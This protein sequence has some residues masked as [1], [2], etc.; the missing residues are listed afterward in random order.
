MSIQNLFTPKKKHRR[1]S[2]WHGSHVLAYI[3]LCMCIYILSHYLYYLVGAQ[4]STCCPFAHHLGSVHS[5]EGKTETPTVLF[6]CQNNALWP[7]RNF[8]KAPLDFQK[9]DFCVVFG[10]AWG[11]PHKHR[12]EVHADLKAL[13]KND[14]RVSNQVKRYIN[15]YTQRICVTFLMFFQ[16]NRLLNFSI[17]F[18]AK[19]HRSWSSTP[20]T[21]PSQ[22]ISC[23][24]LRQLSA[25]LLLA[26]SSVSEAETECTLFFGIS[27]LGCSRKLVNG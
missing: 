11:K 3:S 20:I 6:H 8:L 12:G 7:I 18:N 26:L 17:V 19:I 24:L 5:S 22:L 9:L 16:L 15:I 21:A 27:E 14:W 2:R 25:R 10:A 4:S 1:K 13:Q 23:P